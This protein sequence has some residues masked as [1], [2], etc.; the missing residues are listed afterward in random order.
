MTKETSLSS[1]AGAYCGCRTGDAFVKQSQSK[2]VEGQVAIAAENHVWVTSNL[3]Y[4]DPSSEILGHVGQNAVWVWNPYGT[5]Q[6]CS[7]SS[8]LSSN[9]DTTTTESPLTDR[10]REI[11][12]AIIS[13][14]NT[15]QV[16]NLNQG[17]SR[18]QL[19]V[20]GAIAQ[21]YRGP[22]GTTAPTGY[23]KKCSY[24]TRFRNIAPPEFL[25]AV[26]TTYGITQ[27]AEV[28][29]AFAANGATQ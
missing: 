13:V 15:F 6:K 9:S 24:D 4:G 23:L 10:G 29:A 3:R 16:Q 28:P 14:A 26:S 8:C 27:E 19:T 17:S 5:V 20:L 2:G 1:S 25:Q 18:G 12:A 11:D 7:G 21:Q 22:G